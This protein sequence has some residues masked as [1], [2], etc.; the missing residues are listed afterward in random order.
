MKIKK[1]KAVNPKAENVPALMAENGVEYHPISFA[2]WAED[3]P[4]SPE[5]EVAIAHNG[6]SLLLHYR[7]DEQTARAVAEK[8]QDAVWE[9][10]CVEFFSQPNPEDGIYYNVEC[11]CAG[12]VLLAAG[13][14]RESRQPAPKEVT[15]SILR[16]SSLGS[17]S[18]GE[19]PLEGGWQL[20]LVIP[21]TIYFQHQVE[22]LSGLRMRGNAY[23]CGDKLANPH[24][25][26]L[27]PISL[28]K[29]Q[30]HCPEFFE[31]LELE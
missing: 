2:N 16:W 21:K 4:Y 23:K 1:I 30:F 24:F 9:D 10:S 31:P 13:P 11:N 7:V 17:E 25:L 18:F 22:S 8:D 15:D 5:V 6:E 12:K 26:S 28:P 14:T 20:A 19:K 3:Y 29:P 27:F